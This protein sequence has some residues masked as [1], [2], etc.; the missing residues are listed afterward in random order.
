MK[1]SPRFRR[2]S[3]SDTAPHGEGGW[4]KSHLHRH[5]GKLAVFAFE[6]F[7]FEFS[8]TAGAQTVYTWDA[9]G[10]DWE[11]T[12]AENWVGDLA[13]NFFSSTNILS[14]G[15]AGSTAAF[16]DTSFNGGVTHFP[17]TT[18]SYSVGGLAFTRNFTINYSLPGDEFRVGSS[19]ISVN[20]SVS[21]VIHPI[22]TLTA[23]QSWVVGSGGS[24]QVQDLAG[25]KN[26]TL[27][28]GGA[29]KVTGTNS[30]AGSLSVANGT[31]RITNATQT[32]NF[33]V[34]NL[35]SSGATGTYEKTGSTSL[36]ISTA[37]TLVSGG[38]GSLL[39]SNGTLTWS[40]T[41]S[42]NGSLLAQT[43]SAGVLVISGNNTFTGS[44]TV[45][46]TGI[47]QISGGS[48]LSDNS[49]TT[50]NSGATLD[51]L[52]DET[53]GALAGA[54]TVSLN[55]NRLTVGGTQNG[56]F[57]GN[58][59][60]SGGISRTG[61]G[62]LTL[63]GANTYT[64]ST[65]VSGG[66]LAIANASAL[67]DT[68]GSTTVSSG[69]SLDLSG[70]ISVSGEALSLTGSGAGGQ[71]AL[72]SSSGNN[73]YGGSITL[74]GNTTI[75]AAGGTLQL[76][77]PAGN[78]VT[79]TNVDLTFAGAGDIRVVDGISLGS[80]NLVKSGSG[81]LWLSAN[82]SY[83]GSTSVTA[84]TLR[85]LNNGALSSTSGGTSVSSGAALELSGDLQIG[86]A[87]TLAGSGIS[88]GGALRS[89]GGN[90]TLSGA[91][92]LAGAAQIS[93]DS[94]TLTLDVASGSAVSGNATLTFGGAGNTVVVDPLGLG[95]G[96]LG[97]EGA[98]TLELRGNNTYTGTTTI[99]GGVVLVKNQNALGSGTAG[100]ATTVASGATLQLSG[101]LTMPDEALALS[102]SG[103][104]GTGALLSVSGTNTWTGTIT[105]NAPASI[106]ADSGQLTIDVASGNAVSGNSSLTLQAT[107]NITISDSISLGTGNL[108][109]DGTGLVILAGDN[110]FGNTTVNAGTLQIGNGNGTG[111]L[112]SGAT[113]NNGVLSFLRTGTFSE[114]GDISGNGTL[115]KRSSAT[116]TLGG[117]NSYTGSTSVIGGT[118]RVTNSTGLGSTAG[119]TSVTDGATLE[120]AGG[121]TIGAEALT[122]GGGG[123]TGG[124]ALRS[125]GGT[126]T[127]GG[128]LTLTSAI[129]INTTSG[130]L[131]LDVASGNAITG[132]F[133]IT[134]GG[135][136]DTRILDPVSIG[137]ASIVK[138]GAGS[139]WLA[140]DNDYSG[141]TT[142]NTGALR[143]LSNNALGTTTTG[144]TVAGGASLEFQGGI[145]VAE[146]IS[147]SGNGSSSAGAL[148][149][150]SDTNT[151][152]TAVTLTG[153]SRIASDAGLLLFDTASGAAISGAFDLTVSGAG[154][155]EIAD[156]LGIG[157][158]TLTKEG[159]GYLRLGGNNTYTGA[160][161][162]NAGVLKITN[163]NSLGTADG[164]TTVASGAAL[165]IEGSGASPIFL[166]EAISLSGNGINSGGALRSLDGFNRTTAA[167]TLAADAR[168][169]SDAGLFIVDVASGSSVTGNHSLTVSGNGDVLFSDGLSIGNGTLTKEGNGLFSLFG[170]NTSGNMVI[171]AGTLRFG[172]GF[173]TT[174]TGTGNI[175]N[176]AALIIQ[177]AGNMTASNAISGSGTFEKGGDG[178]LILTGNNI[179]DG[180]TLVGQGAMRISHSNAL[181]STAGGTTVN[182]GSALEI[183][184]AIS[185][186]A[187]ALS[188]DGTGLSN[189]GALRNVSGVN[190]YGGNITLAGDTRINSDSGLLRLDVAS[191][192]AITGNHSLVFG[193][194]GNINVVDAIATGSNGVSKD[195]SGTLTL[196][197]QNTYTGSTVVSQGTLLVSGRVAG[198]VQ[199]ATGTDL[200][201]NGSI[202][203]NATI[204]GSHSPGNSATGVQTFEKNLTYSAGSTLSWELTA[205]TEA[206]R[207]SNYDGIDVG[208]SLFLS[209]QAVTFQA[210]FSGLVNWNDPFWSSN[211]DWVLY[212][213][214]GAGSITGRFASQISIGNDALGNSFASILGANNAGFSLVYTDTQITAHY[215]AIPEP[216][217][218]S[219]LILGGTILLLRSRRLRAAFKK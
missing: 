144:T 85:V 126:N 50:V 26:L 140:A 137:S 37:T 92:T 47:T 135:S 103:T 179:Y 219:I 156:P 216:S 160:T 136:A 63:Q 133:D 150:I 169:A 170:T 102:G 148:R 190:T 40:G 112:G 14:F 108:V 123:V 151:I 34:I 178:R 215:N 116:L 209:D 74:T 7:C 173:T 82:N 18:D 130:I 65:L 208:G 155:V 81:S 106:G 73:T 129:R 159:T 46:G 198:D 99:N 100:T 89:I 185:V 138:N 153:S 154:G 211:H 214:T 176:N 165:E 87:I 90:S 192:P 30:L 2:N 132:N 186:G 72:S 105:L 27:S 54:G 217:T 125:T 97:K 32:G 164:Q 17:D 4:R 210:V 91:I 194:S 142:V 29:V 119:S 21:A 111:S 86:E 143:V 94:G 187:E 207:G 166:S 183:S 43:G 25:S 24:L 145:S 3:T 58:I 114:A 139:L 1:T 204:G 181:G 184:G 12:T 53:V 16:P 9:G 69:A 61:T 147:I 168:I 13:P 196:V 134:F 177:A 6:I 68:A 8:E 10:A 98:G 35:G 195:G 56:T 163:A 22:L 5:W 162:V 49:T 96:G 44:T 80:G 23:N 104:A 76:D 199:L 33:T 75:A 141:N 31:W 115:L 203:G 117:N 191:G 189:G 66:V 60:G 28:G 64:G 77:V 124:G 95:S 11:L 70:G 122:I 121:I 158:A 39:T 201:G 55:A 36:T 127:F 41:I 180:S 84:G 79:G 110:S 19:G 51:F 172:D 38:T 71:G 59:S 15:T 175:S 157:A 20:A 113:V 174:T 52:A 45:N 218:V 188:L 182:S 93:P 57:S 167:I 101:D 206:A 197:G 42:G 161:L 48:V 62:T 128:A 149:N 67:G 212:N 205:N 213:L 88:Q 109:K 83:T 200:R 78:S 131:I 202:G 171:S 193:G 120:L 107:G 146:P 152:T 118:L